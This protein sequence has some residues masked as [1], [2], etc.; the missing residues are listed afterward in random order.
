MHVRLPPARKPRLQSWSASVRCVCARLSADAEIAR[1]SLTHRRCR[2]RVTECALRAQ[3]VSS[4]AAERHLVRASTI[5][6]MR[7]TVHSK[8]TEGRSLS[9]YR[10]WTRQ[11]ELEVALS[12]LL[13]CAAAAVTWGAAPW[14]WGYLGAPIGVGVGFALLQQALIR[15]RRRPVEPRELLLLILAFGIGLSLIYA[16]VFDVS[17]AAIGWKGHVQIMAVAYLGIP[18]GLWLVERVAPTRRP[19][20]ERPPV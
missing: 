11:P 17:S 10:R 12:I 8:S 5:S 18:L 14:R 2:Q 20:G 7:A 4:A 19:A 6:A 9:W 15:F 3:F 16:R 13:P 1:R